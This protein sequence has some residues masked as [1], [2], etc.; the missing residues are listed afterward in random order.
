MTGKD[1]FKEV[2]IRIV[3]TKAWEGYWNGEMERG[4]SRHRDAVE[5]D[6]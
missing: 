5:L 4:C 1:D 2:N 3:G 6:E